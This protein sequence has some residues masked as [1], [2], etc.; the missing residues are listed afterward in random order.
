MRSS[1][2]SFFQ[3]QKAWRRK[4]SPTLTRLVWTQT[5]STT[6][7]LVREILTQ[8]CN[9]RG[10]Q[11]SSFRVKNKAG[12]DVNLDA[13]LSSIPER[14]IILEESMFCIFK[15]SD[16]VSTARINYSN[17][18][19][20]NYKHGIKLLYKIHDTSERNIAS[21]QSQTRTPWP[22]TWSQTRAQTRS[23]TREAWEDRKAYHLGTRYR[24][25]LSSPNDFGATFFRQ[26]IIPHHDYNDY[27]NEHHWIGWQL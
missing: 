9:N 5:L 12:V 23:Q 25:R 7:V 1:S 14:I 15:I 17:K 13:L 26:P 19:D 27:D 20:N 4:P 16:E 21:E 6:K 18:Y 24:H 10:L 8:Q 22:Q 11:L 3:P 2:C